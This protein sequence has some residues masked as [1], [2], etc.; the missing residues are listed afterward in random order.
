MPVACIGAVHMAR[1]LRLP[2]V[3]F[4]LHFPMLAHYTLRNWVEAEPGPASDGDLHPSGIGGIKQTVL[5]G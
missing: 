2:K 3:S 4:R 1:T 5:T